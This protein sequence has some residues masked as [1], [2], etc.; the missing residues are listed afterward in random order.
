MFLLITLTFST[1]S[2]GQ[3]NDNKSIQLAYQSDESPK[4]DYSQPSIVY[5]NNTLLT[6]EEPM[7]YPSLNDEYFWVESNETYESIVQIRVG[8]NSPVKEEYQNVFSENRVE[9]KKYVMI[10]DIHSAKISKKY[11]SK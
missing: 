5:S 3:I 1:L 11:F 10:T 8:E 7:L 9:T 6:L 4:F 2:L